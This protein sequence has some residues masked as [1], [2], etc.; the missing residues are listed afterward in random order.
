MP[1]IFSLKAFICGTPVCRGRIGISRDSGEVM[2]VILRRMEQLAR[3]KRAQV[4]AF[5]DFDASYTR[6]LDPLMREGF[7]RFDSLPTTELDVRYQNFEEYLKT[8]SGASRYDLRRK[9]RHVDGHVKIETEVVN[10]VDDD[11]LSEIYRLYLQ[12]LDRHDMG[13][14][15]LP[16]EFF[17]NV[18]KNMPDRT[19]FFLM[20]VE[21]R[22]VAFLFCLVSDEHLIDYYLGLDYSVAHR[23]HLYFVKF[24]YV[25]NWCIENRIKKYEMGVTG[26]EAKRRLKFDFVPLY[27]YARLR[28]R[29]FRP[30]FRFFCQF[31]KFENFDPSLR[32][33]R[34]KRSEE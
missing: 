19:K 23:Y 18:A 9:F 22:L 6:L 3:K 12:M 28:S 1:N 33:A 5:K 8:L 11:T 2:R 30:V 31:L 20:K 32:Q 25:L 10:S 26:Y 13:F 15:V 17:K 21:G 14:E 16:M 27:I 24:R 34:R 7:S 29:V 4:V